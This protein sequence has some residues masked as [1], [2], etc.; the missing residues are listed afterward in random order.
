[1][2]FFKQ[3]GKRITNVGQDVAQQTRNLT[4]MT[5]LNAKIAEKKEEMSQLLFEMGHDYYQK[6]RKDTDCEEQDY[7]ERL[8]ALFLEIMKYQDEVELLKASNT[9][10]ACGAR[11]AEGASF[12]MNC[13]ARLGANESEERNAENEITVRKC[14]ACGAEAE[15][16]DMFCTMCGAKLD[17]EE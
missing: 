7:V 13:G 15:D 16:E 11:L 5:R 8:N 14:P 3:I 17:W 6:H 2:T 12:C 10:K 4:D 9:C 1:M